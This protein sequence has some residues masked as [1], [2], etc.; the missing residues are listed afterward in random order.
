MKMSLVQ[1]GTTTST[2]RKRK[3]TGGNMAKDIKEII[4]WDRLSEIATDAIYGMFEAEPYDAVEFCREKDLSETEIEYLIADCHK[5]YFK[6]EDD[7][8]EDYEEDCY[9]EEES[10]DYEDRNYNRL[11]D[12]EENDYTPSATNGDYSPSNPWDA[13]GMSI[14]DFI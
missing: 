2:V 6:D 8:D 14:R 11:Y 9:Y 4:T 13:P 7:C 1:F 10:W 5:K 12:D 3:G